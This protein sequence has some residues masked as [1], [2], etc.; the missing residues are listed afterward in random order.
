[1]TAATLTSFGLDVRVSETFAPRHLFAGLAR[2]IKCN[3][4]P[5]HSA[6]ELSCEY[7]VII[8]AANGI[9]FARF[10]SARRINN[11]AEPKKTGDGTTTTDIVTAL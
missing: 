2:S 4:W 1:M 9:D 5:Y 10:S 3:W 11:T 7:C 6:P 8:R